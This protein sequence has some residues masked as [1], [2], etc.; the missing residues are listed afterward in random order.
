MQIRE[1]QPAEL[2]QVVQLY[3]EGLKRELAL[4]SSL[5]PGKEAYAKG[6]GELTK[7]LLKMISSNEGKIFVAMEEELC[8]GYCLVTK[9]YYPAESPQ[10]CGC[11][12]GIY[13][14]EEFRRKGTGQL[15]LRQAFSWLKSENVKYVELY[16][17]IN[18]EIAKGFW[19]K[20]GFKASQ[21]S[22]AKWI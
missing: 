14:K 2:E 3:F 22:C 13:L 5:F 19:E 4:S 12:N 15:L 8:V 7:I 17:V 1:M 16:H 6:L 21:V 10:L 20:N 18:D 11:I 9:K